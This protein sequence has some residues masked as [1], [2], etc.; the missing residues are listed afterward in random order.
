MVN[1]R[2]STSHTCEDDRTA[3]WLKGHVASQLELVQGKE[4]VPFSLH[5]SPRYVRFFGGG[6][7]VVVLAGRDVSLC[8][9]VLCQD[10]V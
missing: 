4:K 10:V 7:V 3:Q 8:F 6:M 9:W 5:T 1:Q 2:W